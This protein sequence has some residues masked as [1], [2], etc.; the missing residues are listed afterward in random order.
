MLELTLCRRTF[1]VCLSRDA[2]VL[3]GVCED[4]ERRSHVNSVV[5]R[6]VALNLPASIRV[7]VAL[8]GEKSRSYHEAQT[9]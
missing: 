1:R 6:L 7:Y 3:V 8:V 2:K 4:S 9:P 5:Y